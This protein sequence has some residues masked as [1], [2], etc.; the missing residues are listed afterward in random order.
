MPS[1]YSL[2]KITEIDIS[3]MYPKSSFD[4][5]H[6]DLAKYTTEDIKKDM[7]DILL[8]IQDTHPELILKYITYLEE[9]EWEI[10]NCMVKMAQL[11]IF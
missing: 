5:N 9:T 2:D 6:R 1:T 11:S 8:E 3:T 4:Y 7:K 10:W